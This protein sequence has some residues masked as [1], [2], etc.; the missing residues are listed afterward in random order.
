MDRP[1]NLYDFVCDICGETWPEL[2]PDA[3]EISRAP[4]SRVTMY[5]FSDHRQHAIRKSRKK[6]AIKAEEKET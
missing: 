5:E 2:P 1:D 4:R 6:T 3:L